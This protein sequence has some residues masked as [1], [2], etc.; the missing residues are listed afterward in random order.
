[1]NVGV[2]GVA[3]A[4]P[5]GLHLVL[6]N[7]QDAAR[8]LAPEPQLSLFL[9]VD[10]PRSEASRIEA[11][12]KQHTGVRA[13]RYVPR[14]RALADLKTGTGL[15]DIVDSLAQNPLPDAFV[16]EARDPAPQA[17]ETLRAEMSGWT[18]V[19]HVQLDSAWAQRLETGL[20][21]G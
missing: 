11:R 16:V 15:A 18:G 19:A 5:A 3:L 20:K 13:F 7:L 4:L 6:A 8:A 1:F 12:L 14:D 17:L 10:A 2:I 21:V 9:A